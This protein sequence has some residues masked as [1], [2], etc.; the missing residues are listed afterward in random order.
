TRDSPDFPLD[1]DWVLG[2]G[3]GI[4]NMARISA[5]LGLSLGHTFPAEG[6]TFTP[7]VTPRVVLDAF[8]GDDDD[9]PGRR[10]DDLDLNFA[11][12]IGLDLQFSTDLT[13]RFAATLGDRDGVG[14]GLVF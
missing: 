9:G 12:D 2:V 11:L 10:D 3:V 5:P 14:I 13:V 6:A 7:F 4:Q 8:L 1:I